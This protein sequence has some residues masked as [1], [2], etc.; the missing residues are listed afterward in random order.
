MIPVPPTWVITPRET[1]NRLA[2]RIALLEDLTY[3]FGSSSNNVAEKTK[4]L[5]HYH[6]FLT[7]VSSLYYL[8]LRKPSIHHNRT[9]DFF[10]KSSH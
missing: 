2:L 5:L 10:F 4:H 9:I 7:R 6:F 8:V 1:V 3:S